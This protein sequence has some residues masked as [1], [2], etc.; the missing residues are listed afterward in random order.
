MVFHQQPKQRLAG[1]LDGRGR[2]EREGWRAYN[3]G[4]R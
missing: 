2:N 4:V 1:F 3:L